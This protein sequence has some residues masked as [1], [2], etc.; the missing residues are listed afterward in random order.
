MAIVICPS[1]GGKVSTTRT[2][3]SHCGYDFEAKKVCPECEESI[4]ATARE[5]PV[6]GYLFDSA[7]EKNQVE[8]KNPEETEERKENRNPLDQLVKDVVKGILFRSYYE[9]YRS[10][11]SLLDRL[12]LEGKPEYLLTSQEKRKLEYYRRL[13]LAKKALQNACGIDLTRH[14]HTTQ[15]NHQLGAT[16]LYT[17]TVELESISSD[18]PL[19]ALES[20]VT[21]VNDGLCKRKTEM[22]NIGYARL[23]FH[24]RFREFLQKLLYALTKVGYDCEMY[25]K[26]F[27]GD[28][29]GNGFEFDVAKVCNGEMKSTKAYTC[30]E[31]FT[32]GLRV[33]SLDVHPTDNGFYLC[34]GSQDRSPVLYM[35]FVSP[36]KVT[37]TH[38]G[39]EEKALTAFVQKGFRE[40]FGCTFL[41][42]DEI[43][44]T[45]DSYP[46]PSQFNDWLEK[47][48]R[49]CVIGKDAL[50]DA[51]IDPSIASA[52]DGASENH[53]SL[54]FEDG[55]DMAKRWETLLE[56]GAITQK[57]FDEQHL[58]ASQL[59]DSHRSNTKTPA[60]NYIKQTKQRDVAKPLSTIN[61]ILTIL[62]VITFFVAAV[63]LCIARVEVFLEE[64]DDG[65]S[66]WITD[67]FITAAFSG[68]DISVLC[69][70]TIL[71]AILML[72]TLLA[73]FKFEIKHSYDDNKIIIR[74]LLT[75][76]VS[77]I[78]IVFSSL[79]INRY[80]NIGLLLFLIL[81]GSC[82]ILI[83]IHMF[84]LLIKKLL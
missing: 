20:F 42:R 9:I 15:T 43:E 44:E 57:Q 41:N 10:G 14:S 69:L 58:S 81:S 76:L 34:C 64:Y 75:L 79:I 8:I 21:Q 22:K 35:Q 33:G 53:L 54:S 55:D 23:H 26:A 66:H 27:I 48:V 25:P 82:G 6:C 61:L 29:S 65:T 16:R 40:Y 56:C 2:T 19:F 47:K 12:D 32:G 24:A 68:W 7:G 31:S 59:N 62:T 50:L 28:T 51:L 52:E 13:D 84:L 1:C 11:E 80:A 38:D 4:D 49:N 67:H 39:A 77:A 5:C 36:I 3:C 45:V 71:G 74:D 70:F 37:W 73:K 30:T 17:L 78:P 83:G 18:A 46:A 60:P 63:F 72:V